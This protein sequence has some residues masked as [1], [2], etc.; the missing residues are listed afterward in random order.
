MSVYAL[1]LQTLARLRSRRSASTDPRP[2]PGITDS[3]DAVPA[4][5]SEGESPS[6]L[7][8]AEARPSLAEL[9]N[10]SGR[11]LDAFVAECREPVRR[12]L[13][14]LVYQ[15]GSIETQ[16]ARLSAGM[17]TAGVTVAQAGSSK[18]SLAKVVGMSKSKLLDQVFQ[19]NLALRDRP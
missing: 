13:L 1:S 4:T 3:Q 10:L 14:A 8:G 17:S 15:L 9:G 12:V 19:K 16:V 2:E 18:N 11:E 6:L 5:R 7:G